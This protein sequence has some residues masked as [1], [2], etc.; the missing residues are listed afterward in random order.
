MKKIKNL[1]S[2]Y[3]IIKYLVEGR[4]GGNRYTGTVL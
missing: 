1:K 4:R 2:I 3:I